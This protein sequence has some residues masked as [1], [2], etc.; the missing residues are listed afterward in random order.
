MVNLVKR[1]VEKIHDLQGKCGNMMK[2]LKRFMGS[3]GALGMKM[4]RWIAYDPK[5]PKAYKAVHEMMRR[6]RIDVMTP[7]RP[8]RKGE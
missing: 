7:A 1:G 2:E 5:N 3:Q 8:S 4:L 6:V